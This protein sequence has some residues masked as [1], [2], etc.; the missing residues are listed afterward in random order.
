MPTPS[1]GPKVAA[2][3][4]VASTRR[5]GPVTP[6][7]GSLPGSQTRASASSP[8]SATAWAAA[9]TCAARSVGGVREPALP[10]R[11]QSS[12]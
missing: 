4:P 2:K 9:E 6:E 1:P 7:P 3:N 11:L 12:G 8:D 10:R 5:H